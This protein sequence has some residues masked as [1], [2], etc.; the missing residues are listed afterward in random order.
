MKIFILV[1]VVLIAVCSATVIGMAF[2]F[3]NKHKSERKKTIPHNERKSYI[4]LKYE[5]ENIVDFNGE[6]LAIKMEQ[7]PFEMVPEATNLHEITDK[8]VLA[9]IDGLLPGFVQGG[10]GI[11]NVANAAKNA[12]KVLYEAIIPA[13][14]KLCNSKEMEG[15]VRGIYRGANNI[16]GHANL[17]EVQN[18]TNVVANTAAAAMGVASMV[19]GQ[20]YMNQINN[21]LSEINDSLNQIEEFQDNEYKSK[22]FA[23]VAQIKKMASFRTEILENEELRLSEINRLNDLEQECIELLGQ[24]NLTVAGYSG[25][26]NLDYKDYEKAI[27]EAQTWYIYQHTLMET[28]NNISGLKYAL[29]LGNVSKEQC[30]ALLPTYAKQVSEASAK[31]SEWH[32]ANIER[33][34]IDIDEQKRK[35]SGLDGVVH[36]LPGLFDEKM[37]YREVAETTVNMIEMQSSLDTVSNQEVKDNLYDEDVRL[38]AKEGKIYYFPQ[39]IEEQNAE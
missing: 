27:S 36:W 7:L 3:K 15:A 30:S 38:I 4:P 19:V 22:V 32:D 1:S 33:L 6:K 37:K 20:Y 14:A 18:A 21:E 8:K 34:Q 23:L 29:H 28:L 13:G 9:Q 12:D 26:S 31:L 5:G 39:R 35:R 11:A 2:L 10:T 24:A 25:K 16:Q 17:V